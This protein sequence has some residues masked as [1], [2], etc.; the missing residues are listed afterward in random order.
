MCNLSLIQQ[1][2]PASSFYFLT[3]TLVLVKKLLST[4]F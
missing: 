1:K 4:D 3:L 2:K